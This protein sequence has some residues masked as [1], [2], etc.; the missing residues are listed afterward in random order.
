[1]N[2][3]RNSIILIVLLVALFV[4]K[5]IVSHTQQNVQGNTANSDS[6]RNTTH[7]I[8]TKYAKCRMDCRHITEDEIKEIIQD[9]KVNEAKSG[10]DTKDKNYLIIDF[11]IS[12]FSLSK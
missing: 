6:F 4:I 5:L 2:T 1:V 11:Q 12:I 3:E 10:H 9:R 7:L 8:L